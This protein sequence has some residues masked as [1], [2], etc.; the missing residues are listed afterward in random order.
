MASPV[1][2]VEHPKMFNAEQDVALRSKEDSEALL[3]LA[4]QSRS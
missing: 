3:G 4:S 2:T 1:G